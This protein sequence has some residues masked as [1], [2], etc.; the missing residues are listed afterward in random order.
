M[1]LVP[2]EQVVFLIPGH[3]DPAAVG[4]IALIHDHSGVIRTDLGPELHRPAPGPSVVARED[5]NRLILDLTSGGAAR[6]CS[7]SGVQD[8]EPAVGARRDHGI[9]TVARLLEVN[10]LPLVSA[11]ARNCGG[12]PPPSVHVDADECIGIGAAGGDP[13]LSER[14]GSPGGC[15]V[16]GSD[17]DTHADWPA[18]LG[19]DRY[20]HGE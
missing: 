1:D 2:R 14:R 7:L 11:I 5:P 16:V 13:A 19:D 8:V 18:T 20:W 15:R 10:V 4:A 3:V 6:G 9:E 17:V 12:A